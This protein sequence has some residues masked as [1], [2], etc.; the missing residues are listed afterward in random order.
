[1]LVLLI[2]T[3]TNGNRNWI[4]IG[5]ITFQLEELIGGAEKLEDLADALTGVEAEVGRIQDGLRLSQ[6][7]VWFLGTEA[8]LSL[9]EA[10]RSVQGVRMELQG[11]SS[12]VRAS[13]RDYEAAEAW[14]S[15]SRGIGGGLTSSETLRRQAGDLGLGFVPNR[16]VAELVTGPLATLALLAVSP[17]RFVV[18]L[19][20]DLAAGRHV[21]S[22][23]SLL[24]GAAG[25]FAPPLTRPSM[26]TSTASRPRHRRG[27]R[28]RPSSLSP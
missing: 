10:Q 4:D 23:V 8:Q 12:Q 11:I 28:C 7:Q 19:G 2:G 18:A 26:E 21:V 6:T 24:N 5:G 15:F 25:G 9:G 17:E 27:P 16:E 13:K 20:A 22:A 3:S 1:V 14:A